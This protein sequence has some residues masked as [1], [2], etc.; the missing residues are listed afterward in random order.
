MLKDGH[1]GWSASR[2][3]PTN[4]IAFK[5]QPN[6]ADLCEHMPMV[7]VVLAEMIQLTPLLSKHR[8]FLLTCD[9]R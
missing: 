9:N 5:T 7:A 2:N 1:D 6:L 4:S 3:D 8:P